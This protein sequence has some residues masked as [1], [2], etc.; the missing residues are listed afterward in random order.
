MTEFQHKTKG[1]GCH[2]SHGVAEKLLSNNEKETLPNEGGKAVEKGGCVFIAQQNTTT[3][4][5]KDPKKIQTLG[6]HGKEK[7]GGP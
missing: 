4:E 1:R 2:S 5:R 6:D 3:E 7:R